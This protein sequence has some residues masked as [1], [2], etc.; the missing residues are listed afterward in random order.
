MELNSTTFWSLLPEVIGAMADSCFVAIDLETTGITTTSHPLPQTTP[1]QEAY[2]HVKPEYETKT[3]ECL[4]SPLFPDGGAA[5]KILTKTLNRKFTTS[6]STYAFLRSNRFAFLEALDSGVSYLSKEEEEETR[7][8]GYGKTMAGTMDISNLNGG[9]QR[10]VR[11]WRTAISAGLAATAPRK[12]LNILVE[13]PVGEWVSFAKAGLIHKLLGH[14]FPFLSAKR[15]GPGHQLRIRWRDEEAELRLQQAHLD[16]IDRHVGIRYVFDALTRGSFASKVEN[17]WVTNNSGPGE[18]SKAYLRDTQTGFNLAADMMQA[19]MTLKAR[20]PILVG[21]NLLHDLAFIY[22]TFFGA[23]PE[24]VDEFLSV[25]HKLFPRI[26]DTKYMFIRGQAH[27]GQHA[28]HWPLLELYHMHAERQFP[29]IRSVDNFTEKSGQEHHAGYDSW[30]TMVLFL[31]QT[32]YIEGFWTEANNPAQNIY[33]PVQNDYSGHTSTAS[34][35]QPHHEN[36]LDDGIDGEEVQGSLLDF[37]P[38]LNPDRVVYQDAG[39]SS[40]DSLAWPLE[41]N[42]DEETYFIPSWSYPFWRD[43]GNKTR[44]NGSFILEFK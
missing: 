30:L 34:E 28:P 35:S 1:V 40:Y 6:V 8:P 36:L 10:F 26:V 15:E 11:F 38:T 20:S 25:I 4:V 41:D 17:G 12:D 39:S 5:S 32:C 37:Y 29:P 42:S 9:L 2:A 24:T 19:E 3:F 33:E 44:I 27:L 14:E 18:P 22:N 23:L 43:F 31:K 16:D 21:H 13:D 7:Q